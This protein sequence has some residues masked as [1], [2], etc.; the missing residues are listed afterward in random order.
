MLLV[1]FVTV[2]LKRIDSVLLSVLL[3][4]LHTNFRIIN[5]EIERCVLIACGLCIVPFFFSY[6][7]LFPIYSKVLHQN[8]PDSVQNLE[9]DSEMWRG[10]GAGREGQSGSQ[11]TT[12]VAQDDKDHYKARD[13]SSG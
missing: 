2:L 12:N 6:G 10:S 8:M 11:C 9:Q 3:A 13:S 1:R 4:H 5:A 7:F